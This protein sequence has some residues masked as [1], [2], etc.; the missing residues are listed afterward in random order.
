MHDKYFLDELN[1]KVS[2]DFYYM[3]EPLWYFLY[4]LY[5]G[6]PIVKLVS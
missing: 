4:S 1:L 2:E 3:P 6:G 5:K